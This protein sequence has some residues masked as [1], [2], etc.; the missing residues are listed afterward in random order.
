[1]WELRRAWNIDDNYLRR[2]K[3][4]VDTSFMLFEQ[5]QGVSGGTSLMWNG[6]TVSMRRFLSQRWKH[7]GVWGGEAFAFVPAL[8]NFASFVATQ[9]SV[10]TPTNLPSPLL[11][12]CRP[13]TRNERSSMRRDITNCQ[14]QK[15]GNGRGER[16]AESGERR[17]NKLCEAW[18]VVA[19]FPK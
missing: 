19:N 4:T 14:K 18:N 2:S 12:H 15:W 16:R 6:S 11:L 7:R 5:L 8:V 17:R 13:S 10:V 3:E 1:M 9:V